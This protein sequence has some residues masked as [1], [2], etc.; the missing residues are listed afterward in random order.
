M[1]TGRRGLLLWSVAQI[2]GLQQMPTLDDPG[3]QPR[4]DCQRM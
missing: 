1:K 4:P 2:I 3:G